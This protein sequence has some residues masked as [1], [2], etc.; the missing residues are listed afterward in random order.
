MEKRGAE[1]LFSRMGIVGYTRQFLERVWKRLI[2]KEL[3][4]TLAAKSDQRMQK[5]ER[6]PI[7]PRAFVRVCR[8]RS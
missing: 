7:P 8:E 3:L 1:G 4:V 6:T 2:G 5:S